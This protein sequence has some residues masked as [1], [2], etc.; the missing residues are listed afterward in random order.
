MITR[1]NIRNYA[2]IEQVSIDFSKNLTIITGETGAGKSILLGALNLIM[3]GRADTKVLYDTTQKCVVEAVFSI[4]SYHLQSFFEENELDYE[5]EL[6]IH[7][8]ITPAGK[9]RAFVNDTPVAL[10]ILKAL[11]GALIDLHQQFDTLDIHH[12]SFQLRMIDALAGNKVLL[13]QYET[14]YKTLQTA[15]KKRNELRERSRA[16]AKEMDFLLFQLNELSEA[17]LQ[18]GEQEAL[19][20]ELRT[21]NN[22]ETIK[23]SLAAAYDALQENEQAITGGLRSVM[24]Q[25]AQVREFHK[26]LP[27]IYERLSGAMYELQDLAEELNAIAEDTEHD[28]ERIEEVNERIN[29]LYRLQQKHQ[30]IDVAALIALRDDL[31]ERVSGFGDLS[32]EIERLTAEITAKEQSLRKQAAVLSERRAAVIAPF[33]EKV[34]TMLRPL[35]MPFAE[36]KVDIAQ[37]PD[38]TTTGIDKINFL[39]SANKG[40][41]LETLKEVASGGEISRLTLVTKSLVASAIPLPT[42]IFDEIDTGVSG[43]VSLKMGGILHD[44]ARHHQVVSITH[45]PQVAARADAHYFVHKVHKEDR[46]VTNVKQ[47]T[48]DERVVEIAT[49]LSGSPPS[50]AALEN[51][52]S[53]LG[54]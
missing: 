2:I 48:P 5:D 22:A 53:L 43:D 12:V 34:H 23:R 14:D 6:V 46:T 39:F 10:P 49:M 47:L 32:G 31:E 42:L 36:F 13:S 27:A 28:P 21:L 16:G 20:T 54:G 4:G 1:L 33:E 29:V 44:L 50:K 8:E 18:E 24:Q 19:E 26:D 45:T 51:A 7:R 38:L 37:S 9:S 11:S 3:G 40:S 17:N 41:R 15:T 35:S 52:A 25:V 30:A